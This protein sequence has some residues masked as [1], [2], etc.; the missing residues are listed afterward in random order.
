MGFWDGE[1]EFLGV[2]DEGVFLVQGLGRLD[3][4][5]DAE[6]V[7]AALDDILRFAIG[8][9]RRYA[10]AGDPEGDV[11]VVDDVEEILDVAC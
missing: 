3:V 1:A 4:E 6:A 5:L 9:R 10:G 11:F 8:D 2:R 7:G